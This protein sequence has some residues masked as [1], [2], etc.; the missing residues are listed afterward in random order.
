MYNQM[1]EFASSDGL[2]LRY[3]AVG[4]GPVILTLHGFPDTY[5]TWDAMTADLEA[6]GFQVI[7][8]ALRGYA[9]SDVA[10]DANYSIDRLARDIA[11]L[12]DHLERD[13]AVLIGH[14]WGASAVYAFA[15]MYPERV[16]K[17]VALAIPPLAVGPRGLLERWARPHNLYLGLGGFSDWWVRRNGFNEIK[18]L[19]SLWS[20]SW[21]VPTDHIETVLTALEPKSRS[22]AAIDYYRLGKAEP[23]DDLLTAPLSTPCLVIYGSDEPAVRRSAFAQAHGVMGKGSK[24]VMLPNVGH[25]PHLEAPQKCIAEVL[26]FLTK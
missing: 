10:S 21:H 9:P 4:H 19:Y 20:P 25:W 26:T 1:N 5:R 22:R 24:V 12:L 11:D 14:D 15:A 23:S 7:N 6:A 2:T 8:L 17:L 16:S 13:K 3:R 18:R